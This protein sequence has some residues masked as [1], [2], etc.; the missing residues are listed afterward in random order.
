MRRQYRAGCELR[1]VSE[2]GGG[3]IACTI[4]S[5]ANEPAVWC[6]ARRRLV[7]ARMREPISRRVGWLARERIREFASY[8]G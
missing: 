6:R 5:V 4:A 8:P 3:D 1:I 7:P 2:L